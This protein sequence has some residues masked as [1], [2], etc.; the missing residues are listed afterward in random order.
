ML[1]TGGAYLLLWEDVMGPTTVQ[2]FRL[3]PTQQHAVIHSPQHKQILNYIQVHSIFSYPHWI[4]VDP[5][6][7]F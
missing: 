3:P 7:A 2:P 1:G 6:S 4:F 5:D